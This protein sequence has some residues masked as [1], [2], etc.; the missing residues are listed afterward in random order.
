[1]NKKK[2]N[3]IIIIVFLIALLSI[4]ARGSIV[5]P[6]IENSEVFLVEWVFRDDYSGNIIGNPN[7]KPSFDHVDRDNFLQILLSTKEKLG[8]DFNVGESYESESATFDF[9][10]EF[11]ESIKLKYG[12]GFMIMSLDSYDENQ[13]LFYQVLKTICFTLAPESKEDEFPTY[14]TIESYDSYKEHFYPGL[15]DYR[16]YNE[17]NYEVHIEDMKMGH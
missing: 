11:D 2:R 8:Y 3:L 17:D 10:I 14:L 7:F 9:Q 5:Y 12:E 4:Y 13:E 1:M 15:I 6:R 16:F